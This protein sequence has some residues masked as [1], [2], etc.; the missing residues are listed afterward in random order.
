M[1]KIIFPIKK[2]VLFVTSTFP[3]N[4]EDTQVPWMAELVK[5][6]SKRVD[7]DVFAPSYKGKKSSNYFDINV[8]RFRYAPAFLEILTHNEG[9]LFKLRGRPW[10][11][12]VALS[13]IICGS[14]AIISRLRKADYKVVHVHWPMP[15]GIFGL[16]A[17]MT[18]PHIRV[19][20]TFYGAEFALTNK[21]PFGKKLLSTIIKQ[22]DSVTAISNFT[23]NKIQ[24][25][26]HRSVK[27]IPFTSSFK[28]DHLT[29]KKRADEKTKRVLF[30]GRLIERKGISYLIDSINELSSNVVLDIVGEGPLL[31]ALKNQI[32]FLKLDKRV[33]LRGRANEE[34]LKNF[35]MNCDVFV[36]PSIMDRWNDTEGLGVVLLEAMSFGKAVIGTRIGGITDIIKDGKNGLLVEQKDANQLASAIK[37][38]L[39]NDKLRSYLSSNGIDT[40]N[41]QFGWKSILVDFEKLYD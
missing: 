21:I 18:F 7:I 8:F 26:S 30:V 40:V 38:L 35:Y 13:Y 10:L 3:L 24:E 16:L 28:I 4:E 14:L 32:F 41:N 1:Q 6:L 17:K 39:S 2:K 19:I 37:K 22:A 23:K 29:K 12:I 25:L 31:S 9:A 36:L 27:V 33:F 20:L 34:E 5:R 11:F 15:Q